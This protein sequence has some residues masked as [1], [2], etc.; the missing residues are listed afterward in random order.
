MAGTYDVTTIMDSVGFR[1]PC[2]PPA[3]GYCW[4]NAPTNGMVAVSGLLTVGDSL[5]L[6]GDGSPRQLA[7]TGLI[8]LQGCA[9]GSS[10]CASRSSAET[11]EYTAAITEDQLA[12]PPMSFVLRRPTSMFGVSLSA[13]FAGDSLYG[14]VGFT[15]Y[16][17]SEYSG[18]FVARRMR[19]PQ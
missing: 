17:L 15:D 12:N 3:Y 2:P 10:G 13:T 9:G 4:P 14:I 18:R 16:G 8:T 6:P 11:G 1:S 7:V 19:M 5:A